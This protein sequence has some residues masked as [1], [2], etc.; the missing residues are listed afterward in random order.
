MSDALP[1]VKRLIL[2][3]SKP[4]SG[5]AKGCGDPLALPGSAGTMDP[6]DDRDCHLKRCRLR[7]LGGYAALVVRA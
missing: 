3:R 2:W 1:V 6:C 5:H 7:R 4:F